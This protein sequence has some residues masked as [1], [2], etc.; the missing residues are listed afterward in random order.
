[1]NLKSSRK[2]GEMSI[3]QNNKTYV[4]RSMYLVSEFD[5]LMN[6]FLLVEGNENSA[7]G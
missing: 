7:T 3:S 6:I 2:Y 5:I 4:Q 1:M